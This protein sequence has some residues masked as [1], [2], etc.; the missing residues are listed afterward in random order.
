[1]AVIFVT[2]V[3]SGEKS[4]QGLCLKCAKEMG[5]PFEI[6]NDGE[7]TALAG[8]MQLNSKIIVRYIVDAGQ[9]EGNPE[10]LSLKIS[11]MGTDGEKE[12]TVTNI[13]LYNGDYGYYA[14]DY[15]GLLASELRTV[16][17]AAVYVG[18]TQV[19]ETM[20]YSVDSY[21]VNASE[22][23]LTPV[24]AMIAYSDSAKAYFG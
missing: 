7:V 2:K 17:S 12:A 5:V 24:R 3:E 4:T 10:D 11:Y 13:T 1:M 16:I 22:P 14:F 9:Y 19:S 20:E 15:A 8:S 6:V 21:G 23:F 18:D